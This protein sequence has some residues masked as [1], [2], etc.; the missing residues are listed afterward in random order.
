ME[1]T[2]LVEGKNENN[3]IYYMRD[4]TELLWFACPTL[5]IIDAVY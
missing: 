3:T 5:I 4:M 1:Q 2:I